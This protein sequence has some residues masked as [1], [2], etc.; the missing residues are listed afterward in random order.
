MKQNPLLLI[1]PLAALA[2]SSCTVKT[3]AFKNTTHAIQVSVPEQKMAVYKH[4]ELI[5]KYPVSTSKF[6]LGDKKGSYKTPLGKF[7][8]AEKIG[9]G[10]PFGAVFK[11]RKWTGEVL[12]PDAPGRDPIVS[13]I[14]WLHGLESKN[15]NTY[16]RCIYIHGT[17]AE[18]D[19]GTKASY[20]CVRMKSKDIIELYDE[21]GWGSQV[22]IVDRRLWSGLH[23]PDLPLGENDEIIEIAQLDTPVMLLA[24]PTTD[25][26][27][28]RLSVSDIADFDLDRTGFESSYFDIEPSL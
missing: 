3:S 7:E 1:A 14:L 4:G 16:S 21:V 13:R 5:K 17:A 19:I 11:S 8:V 20:G 12:E 9:G 10:K 23:N 2:L 26:L 6:G 28:E 27:W 18:K 22:Q 25:P 15:K 24:M